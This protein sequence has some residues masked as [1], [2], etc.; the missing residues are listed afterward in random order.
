MYRI[1]TA[2]FR[3]LRTCPSAEVLIL[4]KDA[5]LTSE[6]EERVARHLDACDFCGAESP[7]TTSAGKP[8][9][10]AGGSSRRFPATS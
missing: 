10:S 2:R 1:S 8:A 9:S 7:A 6:R 5:V 3:K 4:Y